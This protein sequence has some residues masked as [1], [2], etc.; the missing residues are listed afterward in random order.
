MTNSETGVR[1]MD[2]MS[3]PRDAGRSRDDA[4]SPRG[5]GRSRDEVYVHR[6]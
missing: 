6:R 2:E 4:S 1:S 5:A 3:S